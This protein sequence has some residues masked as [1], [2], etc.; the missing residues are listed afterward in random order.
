MKE[1]GSR[2][3]R[4][5]RVERENFVWMDFNDRATGDAFYLVVITTFLTF[6]GLFAVGILDI[7]TNIAVFAFFFRFLV[8]GVIA[9]LIISG[10]TYG[11]VK[12]LF[13]QHHNFPAILRI[14]GYA[15]PTR[16]LIVFFGTYLKSEFLVFLLG[17][18]WLVY[19][20]AKGIVATSELALER[21]LLAS[22]GGVV[23]AAIISS[24]LL[25]SS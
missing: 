2:L 24:I 25:R 19:I 22:G 17:G 13:E 10:V 11:I 15:F 12:F 18:V 4:T 9:W 7:F 8:D 21:A 5:L 23:G 14:T 16:L 20:I 1:I 3:L 6:L